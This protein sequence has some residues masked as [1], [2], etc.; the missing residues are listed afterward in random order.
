MKDIEGR[1]NNKHRQEVE[2]IRE[3]LVGGQVSRRALDIL[4]NAHNASNEY[5]RAGEVQNAEVFAP[6]I[7]LRGGCSGG[8]SAESVVEDH[9]R[10]E[11]DG[12]GEDLQEET[13]VDDLLSVVDLVETLAGDQGATCRADEMSACLQSRNASN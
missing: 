3:D 10:Q 8:I 4:D 9:G 13:G 6:G 1:H 2:H 7:P 5:Q 11:E 12:E